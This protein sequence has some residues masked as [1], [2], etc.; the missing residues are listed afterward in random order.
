MTNYRAKHFDYV[1]HP[2]NYKWVGSKITTPQN[3]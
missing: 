1:G 3:Y 2:I